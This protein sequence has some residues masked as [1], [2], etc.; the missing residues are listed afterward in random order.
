M[1]MLMCKTSRGWARQWRQWRRPAAA[2]RADTL[3]HIS[4]D[5]ARLGP[6][7]R[8]ARTSGPGCIS[9][10]AAIHRRQSAGLCKTI[11]HKVFGACGGLHRVG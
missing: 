7:G 1:A 4:S 10:R 3:M 5:T 6:G 8:C 11:R 2:R 9:E